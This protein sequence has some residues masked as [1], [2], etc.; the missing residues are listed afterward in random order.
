M[1]SF[2]SLAK[3]GMR[4]LTPG[5]G[6]GLP[7]VAR[8]VRTSYMRLS[9]GPAV[10]KVAEKVAEPVVKKHWLHSAEFWGFGG[11]MAGWGLMASAVYDAMYK[12]PEI[13]SLNMTPVQILYSGLFA[14]W[15]WVVKPQNLLLCA[16]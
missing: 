12:G 16:W 13:I 14:R 4:G 1:R 8:M 5:G 15:A 10:E 9:T 6:A 2:A 3:L 7:I 11:A